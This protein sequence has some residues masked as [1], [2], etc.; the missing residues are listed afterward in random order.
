MTCGFDGITES[1]EKLHN[2]L[3]LGNCPS[4]R[5][6]DQATENPVI[7]RLISWTHQSSWFNLLDG[8]IVGFLFHGN[9]LGTLIL[10]EDLDLLAMPVTVSPFRFRFR[11]DGMTR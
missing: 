11:P 7:E 3:E 5:R 2:G 10:L 6:D 9:P 8:I 1:L 4:W